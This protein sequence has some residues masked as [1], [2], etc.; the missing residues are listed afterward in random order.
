MIDLLYELRIEDD[1]DEVMAI[2]LVE[3]PA[4]ESDFIYFD[5]EV[6]QFAAV[7]NEQQKLIGPILV[8]DKKIL[9][10]DGEGQPYHVFFTKDTVKKLAQNY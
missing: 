2:S 3:S 7:D 6:L 9:R 4:I 8:P 1:N 5:K 10:V